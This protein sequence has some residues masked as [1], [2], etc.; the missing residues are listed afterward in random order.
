MPCAPESFLNNKSLSYEDVYL[1]VARKDVI[2]LI[3]LYFDEMEIDSVMYPYN[4]FRER[5]PHVRRKSHDNLRTRTIDTMRKVYHG[6]KRR[7]HISADIERTK[8]ILE[9]VV[10]NNCK[11]QNHYNLQSKES[12]LKMKKTRA[13]RFEW[14][15]NARQQGNI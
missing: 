13:I 1:E 12:R 8:P 9:Y 7:R 4:E 14:R 10:T 15:R 5:Y 11:R 6:F 3:Q 2:E